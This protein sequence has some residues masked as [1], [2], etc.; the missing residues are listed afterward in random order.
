MAQLRQDYQKFVDSNTV[1]VVVGPESKESFKNYFEKEQLPFIGLPD[2]SHKILKE[3]GQKV[4][5]FKLGR[6]P[7]QLI[8]D[9]QNI[10]RFIHYG[11]DMA[12]IPSNAEILILL[13]A[14]NDQE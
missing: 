5:L 6:M 11:H 12:D 8:I 3:L 14:L 13:T 10:V 2:P 7:G 9:K 1:I 4:N